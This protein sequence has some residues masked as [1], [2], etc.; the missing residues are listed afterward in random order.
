MSDS[1][2]EETAFMLNHINQGGMA[3]TGMSLR[4]GLAHAPVRD[5]ACAGHPHSLFKPIFLFSFLTASFLS[6]TPSHHCSSQLK[7]VG[8]A[9][10]NS[11]PYPRVPNPHSET[12]CLS[13]G[14]FQ[15]LAE[16]LGP[17][18]SLHTL[19]PSLL[20]QKSCISLCP[21]PKKAHLEPQAPIPKSL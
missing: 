9:G 21:P 5:L 3:G 6:F 4:S 17:G 1:L 15:S 10:L 19:P 2:A 7:A 14:K 20:L 18:S 12:A 11:T 13:S 16:L 8:S